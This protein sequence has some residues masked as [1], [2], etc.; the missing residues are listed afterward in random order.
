MSR[1]EFSRLSSGDFRVGDY[2]RERGGG[3][4]DAGQ[5]TGRGTL[6]R[7]RNARDYYIVRNPRGDAMVPV[8][9]AVAMGFGR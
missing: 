3:A 7:G 6:G 5:I 9:R 4:F 2:V 8:D 1:A